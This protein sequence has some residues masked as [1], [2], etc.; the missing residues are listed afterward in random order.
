MSL[1]LCVDCGGSKT[2]AVIC[3]I[4]GK[5]LGRAYGG[6]SNFAYLS[7]DDFTSAVRDAVSDAL[8]TC[9]SPPSVDPVALPPTAPELQFAA[10]WFG[11]SGVDGPAAI[12]AGTRLLSALLGIPAGPRLS[13]CNDTYLLAAPLRLHADTSYAV[14]AIAGTG[15]CVVSFRE[16]P[17]GTLQELGRTGGWGWVLGDEG[18]GFHVGREAIRQMLLEADAASLGGAAPPSSPKTMRARIMEHFAV[19]DPM[20]VLTAV[21]VGDPPPGMIHAEGTPAY[22]NTTRE[23]RLSA[24]SPL[25]FEAAFADGDPLALSV[26]RATASGLVDQIA[27]MLRAEDAEDAARP[28]AIRASETVLCF[29]GSLVGVEKYRSLVLEILAERGH[30]FK[31][32]KYVADAAAVGAAGLAGTAAEAQ[33]ADC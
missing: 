16:G 2:S 6:P 30:V 3:D 9:T 4:S 14:A 5:I 25:V 26:L 11:I 22:A 1:Y 21:H 32:V 10:A 33:Q 28:K 13:V 27:L 12:A 23:K 15:S 29:G 8:K 7:A 17:G 31:H 19:E 20:E 24:L 18:G